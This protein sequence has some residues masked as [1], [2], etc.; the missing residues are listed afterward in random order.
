MESEEQINLDLMRKSL[1]LDT[2]EADIAQK[3]E[4]LNALQ[5]VPSVSK[6]KKKSLDTD[7][8]RLEDDI[9]SINADLDEVK[10]EYKNNGFHYKVNFN[11]YSHERVHLKRL[12]RTTNMLNE[13]LKNVTEKLKKLIEQKTKETLKDAIK[14]LEQRKEEIL[15][16]IKA[17]E[18]PEQL[19]SSQETFIPEN[20][21]GTKV[22]Q[23]FS[24][25]NPFRSKEPSNSKKP[26]YLVDASVS[27]SSHTESV[28]LASNGEVNL[29]N[30]KTARNQLSAGSQ[31]LAGSRAAVTPQRRQSSRGH[32]PA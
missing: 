31:K 26:A 13:R 4:S 18:N 12:Q 5:E 6:R 16:E 17:I 19:T 25:L 8:L 14:D 21:I 15:K 28:E 11:L 30:L 9:K 20:S 7:I 23:F 3:K 22:K 29:N 27:Q 2:I 24:G 32:S 1:E 10:K